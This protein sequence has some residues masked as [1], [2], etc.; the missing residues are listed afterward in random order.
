MQQLVVARVLP[1]DI[2]VLTWLVHFLF[3]ICTD[4]YYVK[5]EVGATKK[6]KKVQET[7]VLATTAI[8]EGKL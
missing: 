2:S 8:K 3:G 1:K 6:N 4:I 5:M 7:V